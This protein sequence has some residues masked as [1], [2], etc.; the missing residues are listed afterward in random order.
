[1]ALSKLAQHFRQEVR[2]KIGQ[3]ARNLIPDREP[4]FA[5]VRELYPDG[6]SL[7]SAMGLGAPGAHRKGTKAFRK[8]ANLLDYYSRWRRGGRDPFRGPYAARLKSL[9][10]T[11][12]RKV[13]TPSSYL[14]V[15]QLIVEHGATM[16][17]FEGT[18]PYEP[19]RTRK[20]TTGVFIWPVVLED[21]RFSA[22]VAATPPVRWPWLAQTFLD[23]WAHAYGLDENFDSDEDE[24]EL[25]WEGAVTTDLLF[26]IG[27]EEEIGYDY[28]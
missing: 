4:T 15:L 14:A 28:R 1:M 11:G 27:R 22:A 5:D 24:D 20:V 18:F 19:G 13:A 17:R 8:R 21:Y 2:S 25:Y 16:V 7:A 9:V 6:P 26:E 10:R 12:W 3:P 23:A